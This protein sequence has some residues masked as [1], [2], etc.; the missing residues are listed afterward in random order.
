MLT[1]M[2][3]L[4]I[5]QTGI[6]VSRKRIDYFTGVFMTAR[7][8]IESTLQA[9]AKWP[10]F[11]IRSL[12]QTREFLFGTKYNGTRGPD[13]QP[14]SVRPAGALSLDLMP[15]LDTSKPPK[16][17]LELREM[18]EESEH[19]PGTGKTV[20]GNLIQDN[21]N[22]SEQLR[23]LR[24]Y[25][26]VDQVLKGVLRPPKVDDKG[27][28][29]HEDIP[30]EEDA[31]GM[32]AGVADNLSGMIYE[33]GLAAVICADGRVR[34]HM[35][36]TTETG[37]WRS[38]RFNCQN[39]AKRRD[40]DYKLILKEH[41]THKL[42]SILMASPGCVLIEADFKSAELYGM[43]IMS[44]DPLLLEHCRRNQ[45]PESD[46]D[47][48]DIHSHVAV[49][50]FHLACPPTKKG[51]E[52]IGKIALRV[53]A[54]NVIFGVA[55]GR[56]AKAIAL[57][58]KEEGNPI[59]EEEAQSIIDSIFAR[60]SKLLPF[61]E[62]ARQ[63]ALNER[64]LCTCFGRYRRFPVPADRNTAGEF[65]RQA[66]NFG[67]Q[68]LVASCADRALAYLQDYRDNVLRNPSMFRILLQIHDAVLLEVPYKYVKEVVAHVLP[69]NMTDR[70]SIYPTDLAGK[71]DGR[72]PYH[73]GVDIEVYKHW[74]EKLPESVAQ[75][76]A[77]AA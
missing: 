27:F 8:E 75:Q 77:L 62:S 11:N 28:V 48:Y 63:R 46:P 68:S 10:E 35:Y 71:P 42:R 13:G 73:L 31:A 61:F 18:G 12:I 69:L 60:Y 16:R 7:G 29:L 58:C 76:I 36:P 52:S 65:E 50:A 22:E 54:K 15:I 6:L 51:L 38:A 26:Y 33:K 17:W 53:G 20:L 34:T 4:E 59:T 21:P 72:G 67:I 23:W 25:R 64:W 40:A 1:V 43:A 49:D 57:Q 39:F 41:Y 24:N 19:T 37:R 14:Y 32:F 3:I 30:D 5:H 9:W 44:G 47:Y 70:V 55:Y 2:P 74:G 66:M 45:L 56:M